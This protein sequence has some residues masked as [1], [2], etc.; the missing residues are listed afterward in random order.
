MARLH[1]FSGPWQLLSL[2][3]EGTVEDSKLFDLA[4]R[5]G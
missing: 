4:E 2:D 3:I 5:V 1:F